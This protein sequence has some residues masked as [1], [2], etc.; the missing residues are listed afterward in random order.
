MPYHGRGDSYP[1]L[2]SRVRMSLRSVRASQKGIT[3]LVLTLQATCMQQTDGEGL[4][5]G[6]PN[7]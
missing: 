3:N 7:P 1:A 2:P 6:R 5:Q 4:H